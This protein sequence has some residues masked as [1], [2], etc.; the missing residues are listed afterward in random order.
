LKNKLTIF[1]FHEVS[2]KPSE[3]SKQYNLNVSPKIFRIQVN[4]IKRNYNIIDP[5]ELINKTN[6]PK[7]SAL[8]TFDD[9]FMGAFENGISYL[10]EN[11]IPSIMFLNMEHV[12]NNSPLISA[13]AIFYEKYC[14]EIKSNNYN[15]L[16]LI[17]TPKEKKKILKKI[18]RNYYNEINEYQ[19]QLADL[20]TLSKFSNEQFV[21]FGNHLYSHW[22]SLALSD[23]EYEFNILE[24]K[25]ILNKFKNNIDFLS[26]PNGQYNRHKIKILNKIKLLKVFSSSGKIND[27]FNDFI[28]DRISLTEF[29]YNS[30]KLYL[31]IIKSKTKN[32]FFKK[33]LGLLRKI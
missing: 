12:I 32:Y 11:K 28:L 2:S 15:N 18:N 1:L 5:S 10:V 19:G 14:K 3:F 21:Y 16:H 6:I 4:W 17:L 8:I 9:G 20:E 24:N 31:R 22:N 33:F 25:R 7:N 26:L 23:S 27:N 29:E 30:V 13:E